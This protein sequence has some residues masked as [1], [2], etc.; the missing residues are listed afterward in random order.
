VNYVY[1]LLVVH[2]LPDNCSLCAASFVS[3]SIANLAPPLI[4]FSGVNFEN[5]GSFSYLSMGLVSAV[6]RGVSGILK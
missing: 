1:L 6:S 5:S 4:I 3:N 2:Y